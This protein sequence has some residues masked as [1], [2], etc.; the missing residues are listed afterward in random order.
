[1]DSILNHKYQTTTK[2]GPTSTLYSYYQAFVPLYNFSLRGVKIHI[3]SIVA[4]TARTTFY[5][6]P[7][8]VEGN[9]TGA[10]T[11]LGSLESTETDWQGDITLSSTPTLTAGTKYW[12]RI[13]GEPTSGEYYFSFDGADSYPDG[14]CLYWNGSSYVDQEGSIAFDLFGVYEDGGETQSIVFITN[15]P[16]TYNADYFWDSEGGIWKSVEFENCGGGRLKNRI[17]AIS[18]ETVYFGEI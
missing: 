13:K 8:D 10:G 11:L 9:P 6:H 7:S 2:Q 15:R 4:G 5:I 18:H 16:S 3:D 17:V 12:L 1:M 14:E